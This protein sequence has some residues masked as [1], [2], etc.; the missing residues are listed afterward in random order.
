[1][2]HT[3]AGETP[4]DI[5][6][7]AT[8]SLDPGYRRLFETS[9]DGI[10]VIDFETRKVVVANPSF[11][12]LTGLSRSQL[13]GATPQAI[14]PLGTLFHTPGL[15]EELKSR[16]SVQRDNV[17]LESRDGRKTPVDAICHLYHVNGR[18]FVQCNFRD[19]TRRMLAEEHSRRLNESLEQRV[20]AR[21]ADLEAANRE[22]EAFTYSVSHDL[23]SPLRHIMGFVEILEAEAAANL[24]P[25]HIQ[26]LH[27]I[28]G[29]AHRMGDLIDDLL[30]FSRIGRSEMQKTPV[31]L[32]TLVAEAIDD[33]RGETLNRLITWK[34]HELPTLVVDRSLM[35]QALV[36]LLS[37]AI[38]FTS[39]RTL[40][41][42]EVGTEPS[43]QG[44]HIVFVRDNGVGFDPLYAR[45]IFGVF[46][47]LHNG[48]E[49]EGT[50]IGLANVQRI[51]RRHGGRIWAIGKVD[52]GATFY[53][54]IPAT[55]ES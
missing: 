39:T 11:C 24:P 16:S 1:M 9:Q 49:F 42:I 13:I 21:T 3:S 45:K 44:E 28:A 55:A 23:R 33:L 46:E 36:N 10:L 48:N 19:M 32:N 43:G 6:L 22:L 12:L 29:A 50:G 47:R 26:Y 35:R 15:F 27:T 5:D 18:Q 14:A 54:S 41:V 25:H 34:I 20:A 7:S 37:N 4:R 38:K 8:A 30:A 51:I 40:A 2:P 17:V 31:A 52:A 53:F